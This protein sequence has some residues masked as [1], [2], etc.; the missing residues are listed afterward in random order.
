MRVKN[1]PYQERLISLS[2]KPD[3][4]KEMVPTT[5]V[6]AVLFHT[7]ID[8]NGPAPI[9]MDTDTNT[10]REPNSRK[11]VWES[12]DIMMALDEMF[13]DTPQLVLDTDEY[14]KASEMNTSLNTAGFKFVYASSGG[15]ESESE[16]ESSEKLILQ[17]LEEKK[18]AFLD[19]LDELDRAIAESGG[20][21]R[22]GTDF[23]GVDAEIIPSLE[24]WR[25]QLPLSK[26]IDILDSRPAL[27]KWFQAM[28]SY[29]P[30]SE[31]VAG[32]EYS[33]VATSA[34]FAIF[35]EGGRS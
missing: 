33:W 11:L 18:Q 13:P 20:P 6:P 23:T 16:S 9:D 29:A 12:L 22:L 8:S 14:K 5:Q 25:Y 1:L 30:Y 35:W 24:R 17:E 31:R 19:A 2:N 26:G 21:F 32:D 28:D 15:S 3:W 10:N 7:D 34:M 4:Y 27:V